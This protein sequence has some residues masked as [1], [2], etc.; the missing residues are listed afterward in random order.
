[1]HSRSK[2]NRFLKVAGGVACIVAVLGMLGGHWF[3][4]QSIA[5]GHM[6]VSYSQSGSLRSAISKTFD[7]EHPCEMCVSISEGRQKEHQQEKQKLPWVK[8][9]KAPELFCDAQRVQAPL[10]PGSSTP[11]VGYVPNRHDDFQCSPPK[12]P[13]RA[14]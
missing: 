11:E 10:P 6:L 7:G 14:A 3:L 13:P 9:D 4:L 5:W 8:P 1:M 2:Q 12:P